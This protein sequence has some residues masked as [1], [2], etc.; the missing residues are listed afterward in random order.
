MEAKEEKRNVGG[1][2]IP[3]YINIYIYMC[4]KGVSYIY[5]KVHGVFIQNVQDISFSAKS[6]VKEQ[7]HEKRPEE[8]STFHVLYPQYPQNEHT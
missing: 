8:Q 1:G 6:I 5:T 4:K 3:M 2:S 7:C